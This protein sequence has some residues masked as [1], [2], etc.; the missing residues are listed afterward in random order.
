MESLSLLKY[1]RGGGGA[2][3]AAAAAAA[4]TTTIATSVLRPGAGADDDDD[5]GGGD[6]EGP[7]FDLEFA[8]P[9]DGANGEEEEEEEKEAAAAA[10]EAEEDE[11][12]F[13]FAREGFRS[14]PLSPS[15]DLFF[16]GKLLTL[17]PSSI[18]DADPETP[19][20]LPVAL[21]KPAAKLRVFLLRL[22]KPK[23]A[24]ASSPKPQG[25]SKLLVK[26]KVE[27]SPIVSLFTRDNSSRTTAA[28]AAAA[29]GAAEEEEE[30][31]F[32]REVVHK[33][34]S[35][36]KPLY[37]RVSK[38]YGE[39][40]GFSEAPSPAAAANQGEEKDAAEAEA[41]AEAE[42]A[43]EAS[44][45]PPTAAAAVA[46]CGVRAPRASI[47][48]LKV[49]RRRLGKSRSASAAVAAVPSPRR[50]DDSLLQQEDGI[51]SAIAHCKRSFHTAQ[52][53]ESPFARC[54]SDPGDGRSEKE[55]GERV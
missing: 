54:M 34:L 9:E 52:G 14:E 11:G 37:V 30:R 38:R 7:F 31:R 24:A 8:V 25:R 40:L 3:I 18:A 13:D 47:P 17:D 33:Y 43:E 39:K 5:D 55:K 10:A 12:E 46:S 27:E 50:R 53:S 49:V 48:G 19:P 28:T 32:A 26:L 21:L 44:P 2:A 41:E 16:K 23:P 35:K 20:H 42:A 45:P 29:A 4:A 1:L 36:I 51:Q 22:R 6:D 15:D